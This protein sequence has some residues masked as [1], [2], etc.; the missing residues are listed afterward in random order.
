MKS[1]ARVVV[2]GGGIHG[3]S[4]LYE[5]AHQGWSDVVL[6][7]KGELTSGTTW[8]AAGQCPHFNGS[9]NFARIVDH[10]IRLY[11]N[12][13]KETGQATGWHEC[14][15]IRLA[16]DE[17]ELNW[18]KHVVGIAKQ[19]GIEAHIVGPEE[20]RKRHPYVE[21]HE[22]I[23]GT[24]TLNDGHVDPTGATNALA[25]GAKQ[26]GAQIYRHTLAT[27]I[28]R[29]GSEWTVV[30]EK[31]DI[32]CEHLVIAAGFFTTQVG[33]WLGL[34]A[35]LINVVHQYLVTEPVGELLTRPGELPVIRD[36]GSSSYMR[37]EQKGLLGG[38]YETANIKTVSND[39]PWT[40]NMDLLEPD[41]DHISP[42]LEKMIER[43][44]LFGGV[45]V[46]RTI[47]GFIA[48]T[49]DL[50]PLVG[51]A[52][53]LNNVWLNCGSTT[54]IAQGPGCSKYLVQWLVHG[55]AEISMTSLDPRRFGE[56][57]DDRWVKARTV[58]ASSHMY[59][60]HPP[61]YYF[62][63]G[64][65]LRTSPIHEILRDKGAVFSESMGW[66]RPKWF[67]S[68]EPEKLSYLRNSSFEAVAEE[69]FAVRERVGVLDLTGFAKFEVR[70][71][72][73]EEFL[74]RIFANK[75]PART[76]GMS[77]CHLLAPGGEIDAEMTITKLADGH[78]YLLG[79]GFVEN[80]DQ[81]QLLASRLSEEQVEI[82]NVTGMYGILAVAGPRARDVL[83]PLTETNLSNASFRWLT[84]QH[85][86]LAGAVMRT[87][88]VSYAGE[89]GWELHVPLGE[90][91]GVYRAVMDAGDAHG[92]SDF[93]M[94]AL[95]SLRMEKAYRG[96]GTELTNE[97][98]LIEADM[99]RFAALEKGEFIGREGLLRRIR[100]G[101]KTKLACV[102][103]DTAQHDVIGQ[104]PVYHENRIVG[105]V[106]SGGYGHSVAKNLAFVYVEPALARAG[107]ALQIEMLGSRYSAEVLPDCA[108]DP[109]NSKMRA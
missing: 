87:L 4:T 36:P 14:G 10:G 29:S 91:L 64:R 65:P 78:F 105:T 94:Y 12:L 83:Q 25:K 22:V 74:N 18:H 35:P 37:Q 97:I 2:L 84:A 90:M 95:N 41:L 52:P 50:V 45:G 101:I 19:A 34:R 54:G 107:A 104:E 85:I 7:E 66:E 93:G 69:C 108:Y 89:L 60:V 27:G 106:T 17:E 30:T 71:R 109:L 11:R 81:S 51:P 75:I 24:L 72:G 6:I 63:A 67:S 82:E 42:W 49:P 21:L 8:H 79:A 57:H 99:P 20:I 100:D 55:A 73:A 13:E 76:G 1:H 61:G 86:S 103:I 70:G 9:L 43:F 26:L 98:S 96:F 80:R 102:S 5:L 33:A 53:G 15:G 32:T 3:V 58:E 92:I 39:V 38:P 62:T 48:H 31:G 68:G 44:P 77:L 56:I 59:D 46:R 88:R 23:G 40:F 16:R 47:S 28:R